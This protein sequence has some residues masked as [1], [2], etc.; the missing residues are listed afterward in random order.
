LDAIS[1]TACSRFVKNIHVPTAIFRV[2]SNERY[3][4]KK[5]RRAE[6]Q[7]EDLLVDETVARQKRASYN[8][9]SDEKKK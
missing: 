1:T 8:A 4:C 5:N 6:P 7:E 3:E 9:K 2:P